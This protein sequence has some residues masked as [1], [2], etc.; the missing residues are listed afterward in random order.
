MGDKIV[1]I[2]DRGDPQVFVLMA[3]G[4]T[5]MHENA[6]LRAENAELKEQLAAREQRLAKLLGDEKLRPL[7]R[8]NKTAVY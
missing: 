6:I 5:L 8:A 7:G 4:I 2:E 1:L 3:Q